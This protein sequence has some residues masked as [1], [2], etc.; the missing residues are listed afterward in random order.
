MRT[1]HLLIGIPALILFGAI[2]FVALRLQPLTYPGGDELVKNPW[3]LH[4]TDTPA[5]RDALAAGAEDL[6]AECYAPLNQH[7]EEIFD[8]ISSY[9]YIPS[10]N[11][12][13][14]L[15]FERDMV[16]ATLFTHTILKA[17]GIRHC[18]TEQELLDKGYRSVGFINSTFKDSDEYRRLKQE[19]EPHAITLN[20]DAPFVDTRK[21]TFIP[22]LLKGGHQTYASSATETLYLINKAASLRFLYDDACLFHQYYDTSAGSHKDYRFNLTAEEVRKH[23]AEIYNYFL[24]DERWGGNSILFAAY[25]PGKDSIFLVTLKDDVADVKVD[26]R[27]VQYEEELPFIFIT[28]DRLAEGN[29]TVSVH[30]DS[31]PLLVEHPLFDLEL[32]HFGA[33]IERDGDETLKLDFINHEDIP[34]TI[35]EARPQAYC[36]PLQGAAT[37]MPGKNRTL[38]F[39]CE[40]PDT[41]SLPKSSEGD[42]WI[43]TD[44]PMIITSR[45]QRDEQ[46]FHFTGRLR[47]SYR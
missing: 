35:Q 20:R 40:W 14:G 42:P 23:Y 41:E 28:V 3:L 1:K 30:E 36:N 29:H 9:G 22:I 6:P 31:V 18:H 45:T 38:T 15:L 46:T 13:F 21:N 16:K 47:R 27:H 7:S 39:T 8:I 19:M 17:L 44:I 5:C 25:I 11:P 24:P 34:L 12:R 43:E 37:V 4:D 32:R 33:F 26:G 10:T 2:V